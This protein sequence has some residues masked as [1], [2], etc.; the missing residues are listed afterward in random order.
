MIQIHQ[1]VIHK[2]VIILEHVNLHVMV[3]VKFKLQGSS[4]VERVECRKFDS[5]SCYIKYIR[6]DIKSDSLIEIK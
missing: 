1:Q 5:S 3:I 4:V 2:I 6:K